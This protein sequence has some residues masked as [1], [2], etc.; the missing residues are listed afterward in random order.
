[1]TPPTSRRPR[2]SLSR[3]IRRSLPTAD[4]VSR[5]GAAW[6]TTGSRLAAGD[7]LDP[8]RAPPRA[9]TSLHI[10]AQN[11]PDVQVWEVHLGDPGYGFPLSGLR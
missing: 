11:L 10:A 8:P 5:R 6:A 3:S 4:P 2:L 7:G 1:M 9:I